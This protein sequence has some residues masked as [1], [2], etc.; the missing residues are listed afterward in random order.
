[1]VDKGRHGEGFNGHDMMSLVWLI[2]WACSDVFV[3]LHKIKLHKR[4]D[5]HNIK[6]KKKKLS[7]GVS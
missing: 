5:G 7:G 3:S 2:D 6:K 4:H 1:M